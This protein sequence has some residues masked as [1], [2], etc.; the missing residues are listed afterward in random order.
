MPATK[1]Y[2]GIHLLLHMRG[3]TWKLVGVQRGLDVDAS[4]GV[5]VAVGEDVEGALGADAGE[6]QGV[7]G[8]GRHLNETNT[9]CELRFYTRKAAALVTVSGDH[10]GCQAAMLLLLGEGSSRRKVQCVSEKM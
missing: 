1:Y 10:D 8:V 7:G 9:R 4:R 5:R 2:V 3:G 6:G